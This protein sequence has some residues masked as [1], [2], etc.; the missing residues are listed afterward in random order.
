ML[1]THEVSSLFMQIAISEPTSND[2]A[3]TTAQVSYGFDVITQLFFSRIFLLR[4]DEAFF[5]GKIFAVEL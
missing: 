3:I 2:L 4:S 5:R 1:L